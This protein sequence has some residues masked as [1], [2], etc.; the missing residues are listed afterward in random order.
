MKSVNEK[1]LM[2]LKSPVVVDEIE[3]DEILTQTPFSLSK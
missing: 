1:H 3:F 2:L